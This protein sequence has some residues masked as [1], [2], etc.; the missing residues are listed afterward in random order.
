[1]K[2]YPLFIFLLLSL[3]AGCGK[4]D[5]DRTTTIIVSGDTAGWIVPC[6]CTSN[7]SG[8]LPRRATLIEERRKQG[9]VVVVEV[10]GVPGGVTL[11]DKMK[12]EAI[13]QGESAM[14]IAAHNVGRA[15]A[16][17]GIEELRRLQEK[18]KTPWVS[19]NTT[20]AE[21]NP[22]VEPVRVVEAGNRKILF[23][24]VLSQ[25]YRNETI[26]VTPPQQAV[27]NVLQKNAGK[28][29]YAVVL[30][31]MPE[32]ELWELAENLPEVDAVVGGPTGQPVPP[33]YPQGYVLMIS[34]TRQGKFIAA[35]TLPSN[36]E[37]TAKICGEI[38][39]LDGRFADDPA[40]LENVR[41]F[42]AEL[43]RHDLSPHDTPFV[44]QHGS[45]SGS[46]SSEFIAGS[47]ACQACHEEEYRVW[48]KSSHAGAWQ[49]LAKRETQYDPDCQR[50][51]VTGYGQSG[52]FK[53]V[54]LSSDR[55]GVG[56]ESCH[57]G[58][59][60][61]CQKTSVRTFPAER[62]K[63]Q[64]LHCHDRENSPHFDADA[65]WEKIRH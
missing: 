19:A 64:C 39:E 54:A 27:L 50:C 16:E 3:V 32:N 62:A 18:W 38:I 44:E 22:F 33:A 48:E 28:Y 58:A 37:K 1:M 61:H 49:S 65:Y 17:L 12:F 30:A 34:A 42:Y 55:F 9:S 45:L 47:N 20:D 4:T 14:G 8:G 15:E 10:G 52:G 59:A 23:T 31:Y 5:P 63:E 26:R 13:L 21:G 41:K 51:H 53:T 24:G 35:L 43:K 25:K 7:Q 36:R 2:F 56:C 57:G 40:Q 6:G 46:D 11:Y 60:E 29:D